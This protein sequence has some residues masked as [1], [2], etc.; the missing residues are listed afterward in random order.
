MDLAQGSLKQYVRPMLTESN[1]IWCAL[2]APYRQFDVATITEFEEDPRRRQA[3]R[4]QPAYLDLET[5]LIFLACVRLSAAGV[6]I[7]LCATDFEEDPMKCNIGPT[8]SQMNCAALY[9]GPS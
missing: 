9:Y 3:R 6:T 8:R 7:T 2:S 4:L 5:S 1:R